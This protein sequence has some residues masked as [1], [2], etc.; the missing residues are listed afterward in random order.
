MT[1]VVLPVQVLDPFVSAVAVHASVLL[2]LYWTDGS[3][4]AGNRNMLCRST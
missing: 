4:P 3:R 1:N 2:Y